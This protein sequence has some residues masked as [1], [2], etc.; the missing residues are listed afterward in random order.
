MKGAPSNNL[1]PGIDKKIESI[2]KKLRLKPKIPPLEFITKKGEK[3]HRYYS[4][5][6]PYGKLEK[7]FFYARINK[8]KWAKEKSM[9]EI[10]MVEYI[11]NTKEKDEVLNYFPNY[12]KCK[13][14]KDFEWI[15][16]KYFKGTILE[17]SKKAEKI[18]IALSDKKILD[19]AKILFS[20]NHSSLFEKVSIKKF[21]VKEYLDLENLPLFE[22]EISLPK[23]NPKIKELINKNKKFL[24]EENKYFTHGDFHLGNIVVSEKRA[25]IVDWEDYCLNNFAF[26]TAFFFCRLWR[27]KKIRKKIIKNYFELL[28]QEEK[29]KFKILFRIDTL[30][31]T[32]RDIKVKPLE[33]DSIE[34]EQRKNFFKEV[35]K[36][37]I[38]GFEPLINI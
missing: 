19:L 12:H 18:S 14:E 25:K 4:I 36:N 24:F 16:T 29:K 21:N 27:E 32:S 11:K 6:Y 17:S 1:I 34:F 26:D 28:S 13:K 20:I 23:L 10:A 15:L 3:K 2:L 35:I 9:N 37:S 7:M 33:F 31:Q 22:K 38:R 30:F 5:C 8:N